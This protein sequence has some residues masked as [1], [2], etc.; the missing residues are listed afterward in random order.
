ME[1]IFNPLIGG[2]LIGI[3]STV[4]LGGIGRISGISGI[5]ASVISKPSKESFWKYN[6]LL[7]LLLGGIFSYKLHPE[8]FNYD[9]SNNLVKVV[10]AGLLVGFGTR[11]GNGCT[12]GHGVCGLPRIA[13]RSIVATMTFIFVG[14]LTVSIEGLIK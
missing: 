3:S 6:F 7:G 1:N 4:L 12:S 8:L 5:L 13:K 9:V 10:V 11:L 2:V 14:I